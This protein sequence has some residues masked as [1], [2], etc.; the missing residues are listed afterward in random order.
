MPPA[1]EP[2]KRKVKPK[3]SRPLVL[4]PGARYDA[5][6][7]AAVGR[8]PGKGNIFK[9]ITAERPDKGLAPTVSRKPVKKKPGILDK[10]KQVAAVAGK[11]L[12]DAAETSAKHIAP[13]GT[14]V[15]VKALTS[16]PA[17]KVVSAGLKEFDSNKAGGAAF[18]LATRPAPTGAG[19]RL[20]GA[21]PGQNTLP[22]NV[23][24]HW[25]NAAITAIEHPKVVKRIPGDLVKYGLQSPAAAYNFTRHPAKA[26]GEVKKSYAK[27]YDSKETDAGQRKRM[28]KE[29]I[30]D[31]ALDAST[32]ASV[33]IGGVS[34]GANVLA[35]TGKLGKNLERVATVRPKLQVGGKAV[36]QP[37]SNSLIKNVAHSVHDAAR[38]RKMDKHERRA[39]K[40][41][42]IDPENAQGIHPEVAAARDS[43]AVT[44]LLTTSKSHVLRKVGS[45]RT[46]RVYAKEHARGQ[47][48]GRLDAQVEEKHQR[49]LLQGSKRAARK[50]TPGRGLT[51]KEAKAFYYVNKYG[52]R[53]PAQLRTILRSELKR[54][55]HARKRDPESFNE[56]NI[57]KTDAPTEMREILADPKGHLSPRVFEVQH[58]H[59]ARSKKLAGIDPTID[60]RK[61]DAAGNV[62]EFQSRARAIEPQARAIGVVR[63]RDANGKALETNEQFYYRAKRARKKAGL[64]G[65]GYVP[66]KIT[67]NQKHLVYTVGRGKFARKADKNYTGIADELGLASSQTEG[68]IRSQVKHVSRARNWQMVSN[69]YDRLA[70]D[71]YK[72]KSLKHQIREAQRDGLDLSKVVFVNPGVVKHDLAEAYRKHGGSEDALFNDNVG[73]AERDAMVRSDGRIEGQHLADMSDA[74]LEKLLGHVGADRDYLMIPKELDDQFTGIGATSGKVGRSFDI[75]KTKASRVLL[76]NPAWLQFQAGANTLLSGLAGV[77]PLSMARSH[78]WWKSLSEADRRIIEPI[79]GAHR[80]YDHQPHLGS[81]GGDIARQYAIL[82]TTALWR[83][84]HK[85]NPLD[86]I[87]QL[88]NAQNTF[89]RRAVFYNRARREAY[90]QMNESAGRI[91]T[92]MERVNH[93]LNLDPENRIKALIQ[94]R[95]LIERTAQDVDKFLGDYMSYTPAERATFGRFVMFY[96]F[97]RFALRFTFYTMPVEHPIMT[98]IGLKLGQI[99]RDELEKIF[100]PDVPAWHAADWYRGKEKVGISRMSPYFPIQ[101]FVSQ[102]AEDDGIKLNS[103]IG[104]LP[105]LAQEAVN[106]ITASQA[107]IGKGWT[108]KGGTKRVEHGFLDPITRAKIAVADLSKVYIPGYRQV[109][110]GQIPGLNKIVPPNY[111]KQGADSSLFFRNPMVYKGVDKNGKRSGPSL[112]RKA[113]NAELAKEQKRA[114]ES[115]EKAKGLFGPLIFPEDSTADLQKQKIFQAN[116]KK[117]VKVKPGYVAPTYSGGS[118]TDQG[119][120]V[121]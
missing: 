120:Y 111:G 72:G 74:D 121:K 14:D 113:A 40:E 100:G 101:D 33:G 8:A 61:I 41:R 10:V 29:G 97:M 47:Q 19:K 94:D 24:N 114:V 103:V 13:P 44:P 6:K 22:G 55:E 76:A 92:G 108:V 38:A 36:T 39:W 117:K 21:K 52:A 86:A 118:Y 17:R 42:K 11:T 64:G 48:E 84:A 85:A 2:I 54:I 91:F 26:V 93:I 18:K 106:Q 77:G 35:K 70:F 37:V 53:N 43:A 58:E 4:A 9:P 107:S 87:F 59:A 82:K 23:V 28:E 56:L 102:S 15:A 95:D 110:Q 12:A 81:A 89:F 7:N 116:K 16:K 88:D 46:R 68:I 45:R 27:Q 32:V 115:G 90:R 67:D 66:S 25:R 31:Y 62:D 83:A 51:K 57:G 60:T 80:W 112:A 99:N 105:P 79:I 1:R 50:N 49:D 20:V 63:K 5:K 96:G 104:Y 69:I 98:Q 73:K 119:S 71:R 78:L 3:P 34:R 109:E 65:A 30:T 75:A